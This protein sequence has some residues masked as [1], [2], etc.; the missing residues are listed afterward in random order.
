MHPDTI[1]MFRWGDILVM[2]LLL[3]GV[4]FSIPLIGANKPNN[5]EVFRDNE[6]VAEYP[7]YNDLDFPI[8]G[9]TG[10]L[11]VRI[12]NNSV[13]VLSSDCPHH[14]CMQIG[15]ISH[16][17]QQIVCAPNHILITISNTKETTVPDG[18]AR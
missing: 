9:I 15:S 18:I 8:R 16:S 7:L 13:S 17:N 6:K 10:T 3:S 5:V 11:M 2:L 1:K 12:K 14:L 4:L